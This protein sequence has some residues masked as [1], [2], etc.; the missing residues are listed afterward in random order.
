MEN[1]KK[2]EM[3]HALSVEYTL[4]K[5]AME[6]KTFENDQFEENKS[7]FKFFKNL[8]EKKRQ[9]RIKSMLSEEINQMENKAELD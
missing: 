2:F 9:Y 4:A 1:S 6:G 7:I 8:D 5:N 3:D